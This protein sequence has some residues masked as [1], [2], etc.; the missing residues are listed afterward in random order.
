MKS[1][2]CASI[3]TASLGASL[4]AQ[5]YAFTPA[6][7]LP[8]GNISQLFAVSG[9]GQNFVGQSNSLA[10]TS[11]ARWTS[12]GGFTP[13]PPFPGGADCSAR[14]ISIDG[15]FFAGE[16]TSLVGTRAALW[17]L[18]GAITNLG[19][20]PGGGSSSANAVSSGGITVVGESGSL[21]GRRAFAW[22]LGTGMVN[23]GTLPGG[24]ESSATD[25]S[26]SGA[27]VVG[28]STNAANLR[29]PFHW[30]LATGMTTVPSIFPGHTDASGVS[31][32][33]S[34][35]CGYGLDANGTRGAWV[36][37]PAGGMAKLRLIEPLFFSQA[38]QALDISADGR[39][40]V[41][42]S[43]ILEVFPTSVATA[44]IRGRAPL[45]LNAYLAPEIPANWKL[46]V[47][48]GINSDGT[49]ICGYGRDPLN[50][51]QAWVI[52]MPP[53]CGLAD[54]GSQGGLP[55]HDGLL[56]NNDFVAF[57][58]LFFAQSQLA[59]IGSQGGIPGPDSQLDNN[60]FVVLIDSF[61]GGC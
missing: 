30:T 54:F 53:L 48:S 1:A 42:V 46:D 44:W 4:Q 58:N 49:V 6:G 31:A 38:S 41:G 61:F 17:N 20:L 33:G 40:I 8:G 57:I 13:L 12:I 3:V 21:G 60:D 22:S 52:T 7:F 5:T 55:R 9:S 11:A 51:I 56:D 18:G 29:R 59:D 45:N 26:A 37:T 47:A 34:V 23:L 16:S 2:I 10:S 39:S 14:G 32:D 35:T 15:A 27:I 25:C 43:Q 19:T 36:H 28:T 24:A 50:R